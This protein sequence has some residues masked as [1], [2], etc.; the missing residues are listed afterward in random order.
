MDRLPGA[1]RARSAGSPLAVPLSL[2][3]YRVWAERAL[4][5]AVLLDPAGQQR[6]LELVRSD[7]MRLPWRAQALEAMQRVLARG[8]LP[9]PVEVYREL[10]NDPDLP[11]SVSRDAVPVTS[12]MEAAPRARHA[13]A[14]AA[15]V[16]EGGIREHMHG[17]G[18]RILQA[19][20]SGNTETVLWRTAES[21]R[22]VNACRARWLALPGH[23]RRDLVPPPG[24][25]GHVLRRPAPSQ[26][27]PVRPR[28]PA[29]LAAGKKALRDL[30]AAPGWLEQVGQWLRPEHFADLEQGK[31]YA[32][33]QEMAV[34]GRPVDP[35][36]ISWGAARRGLRAEPRSLEGGMGPFAVA[37]A[38]DV[39]RH[40]VLAQAKYAG[41]VIQDDAADLACRPDEMLQS[42]R[43]RLQTLEAELKPDKQPTPDSAL[44]EPDE[45]GSTPRPRQ[46]AREAAR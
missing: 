46:A 17:T 19:A 37:S 2:D 33:M 9:G 36:T 13:P 16:V 42:A 43:E 18:S 7:D 30:A 3:R 1:G 20:G 4:L 21:I 27:E 11:P 23:L 41:R 8:A 12:L 32:V 24:V 45:A 10:Q 28:G 14:Y 34:A 6:V 15:M 38:R 26:R 44:R 22:D 31:L 40:G 5:G 25:T 39:H 35:V 29:A